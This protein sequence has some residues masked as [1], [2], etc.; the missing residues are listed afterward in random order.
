MAGETGAANEAAAA[1]WA[2]RAENLIAAQLTELI[3]VPATVRGA[4][5]TVE[6]VAIGGIRVNVRNGELVASYDTIVNTGRVAGQGRRAQAAFEAAAVKAA[7]G[8]QLQS[9]RVA[10]ES[11]VNQQWK[12]YLA[13]IGYYWDMIPSLQEGSFFSGVMTKK[14]PL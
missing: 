6:G 10:V 2:A 11:I 14:F 9:A 12:E 4:E 13:S 5:M 8:A 7:R 3:A 1:Q